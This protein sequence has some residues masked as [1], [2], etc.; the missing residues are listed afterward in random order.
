[1]TTPVRFSA[2]RL[3]SLVC[4]VCV[5]LAGCVAAYTAP[6]YAKEPAAKADCQ[7]GSTSDDCKKAS[8]K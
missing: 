1:M 4:I 3:L 5:P 2:V 8:G 6:P 7:N